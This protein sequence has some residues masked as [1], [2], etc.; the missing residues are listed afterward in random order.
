MWWDH[1]WE[2]HILNSE[3]LGNDTRD[4]LAVDFARRKLDETP[5]MADAG[6]GNLQIFIE[7]ES[8]HVKR[9]FDVDAWI[10]IGDQIDYQVCILRMQIDVE[11]RHC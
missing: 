10:S 9:L 11:T 8:K 1:V 2:I 4:S 6:F 7:V 3:M 5:T